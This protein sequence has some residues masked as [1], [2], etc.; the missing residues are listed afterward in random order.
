MTFD[1]KILA[2]V[3]RCFCFLPGREVSAFKIYLLCKWANRP[4]APTC[5][6]DALAFLTYTQI[7]DATVSAA[8]CKLVADLK[9]NPPA[10]ATSFWSR[11]TLLY[12]MVSGPAPNNLSWRANLKTPGTYDL[13]EIP[14]RLPIYS[15]LG[16]Q[17]DP[18]ATAYLN[19]QYSP[20]VAAGPPY[21]RIFYYVTTDNNTGAL[22]YYCGTWGNTIAVSPRKS[23]GATAA[24]ASYIKDGAVYT[25]WAGGAGDTFLG[26]Y[27][28]QRISAAQRQASRNGDVPSAHTNNQAE[29][30]GGTTFP[31]FLFALDNVGSPAAGAYSNALLS[32]FS[33]GTPFTTDAEWLAYRGIWETFQLAVNAGRSHPL[34]V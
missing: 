18:A 19:T 3:A 28:W 20:A 26:A 14:G 10:P 11:E 8:I 22:A 29:V 27:L 30:N 32:G 23:G 17:G 15:A 33:Y 13:L 34:G 16:I 9:S 25:A 21:P 2:R 5:D 12:P 4:T 31:M 1:P 24:R 6:P 7:T